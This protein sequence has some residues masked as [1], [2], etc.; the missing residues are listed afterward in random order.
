MITPFRIGWLFLS[1]TLFTLIGYGLAR[2]QFNLLLLL[3]G[4]TFWGYVRI[5]RPLWAIAQQPLSSQITLPE[6]DRFLFLAAIIFR[7]SLL[8]VIP[9]LSDDYIRFVWDGHL[10]ANGYNPYLYLPSQIIHTPL[11]ATAGLTES[12]YKS[13]NSP[14]YF[15]VYPT[16]NQAL[17]GLAAWLS[18]N[19]LLGNLIGLRIPILL[20][21]VGTLWLMPKLLRQLNQ[22]PNL[23]LLYGL[24]PLVI[25]EL[26]GNIHYE[27]VMIF[28][29]LLAVWLFVQKRWFACSATLALGIATKLLPLLFFPLLIRYLGW[30]RGLAFGSLTL[31]L[32]AVLFFP[33]VNAELIRNLFSSLHLYFQKFEFNASIYYLIRAVGYVVTGNSIIIGAGIALSIL[34]VI[35][36]FIIAFGDFSFL[37]GVSLATRMLLTMSLYWL[38]ATTVHPWYITSLVAITLFTPFRYPLV[39][40]GLAML[41]YGAYRTYPYNENLPLVGLEY[42]LLLV[43]GLYEWQQVRKRL[44]IG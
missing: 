13:L 5:T 34:I 42:V 20:A 12:L 23:A 18:A 39:W 9:N 6:P 32:T 37:T 33:F 8:A 24:N 22:N 29:V 11:A 3:Y 40:S 17:F 25:L 36:A 27:S 10:V 35:G 14:N 15:T 2:P 26:T 31:V 4:L 30:K 1:L 44:V 41:T 28:F 7:V 43:Y 16:V 21:E 38:L 19:N